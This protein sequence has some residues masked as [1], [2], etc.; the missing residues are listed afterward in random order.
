ME[1]FIAAQNVEMITGTINTKIN[2]VNYMVLFVE[3]M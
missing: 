3:K 2:V 1:H